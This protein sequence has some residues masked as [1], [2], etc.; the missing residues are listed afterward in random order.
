MTEAAATPRERAGRKWS[1]AVVLAAFVVS[2]IAALTKVPHLL[3]VAAPQRVSAST[4][5]LAPATFYGLDTQLLERAARDIPRSSTYTV[6]TGD[7]VRSRFVR[8]AEKTL[9]AYWLLP[10][11]RTPIRSSD[12]IVSIGGDLQSLRL[13]YSRLVRVGGGMELA[14]RVR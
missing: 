9:L 6:V 5:A 4:R 11:R 12:W 13:R 8:I 10:R 7:G 14:E 1:R 3:R 2:S